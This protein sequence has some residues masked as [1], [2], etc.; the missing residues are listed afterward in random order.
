M[1]TARL[2]LDVSASFR[3]GLDEL[4]AAEGLS[5][6]EVVRRAVALLAFARKQAQ[7]GRQLGFFQVEDG[8]V[9]VKE[10]VSLDQA[11][12]PR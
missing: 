12:Q 4:A 10:V 3:E 2:D 6:S 8:Q 11:S 5:R 1:N 9:V 7:Q